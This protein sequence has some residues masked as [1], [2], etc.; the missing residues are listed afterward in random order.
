MNLSNKTKRV[1]AATVF[2]VVMFALW[3]SSDYSE[4]AR[5][6]FD[7]STTGQYVNDTVSSLPTLSWVDTESAADTKVTD[8][9][10]EG[11]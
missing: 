3:Y 6:S 1:I 7:Q 8:K 4:S 2:I 11:M 10:V 9:P 5:T